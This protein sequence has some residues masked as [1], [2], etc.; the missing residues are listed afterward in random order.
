MQNKQFILTI[1]REFGSGG[2]EIAQSLSDRLGLKLYDRQILEEAGYTSQEAKKYD[3]KPVN[4]LLSRRI[5]AYSNSI[6]EMLALRTFDFLRKLADSGESFIVVGRCSE[7]VLREFPNKLSLF[8]LADAA[9]K[10]KKTM[11]IYG[12]SEKDALD[13]MRKQDKQRKSYHNYYCESKW[14]DSRGYDLCINTSRFGI[15]KTVDMIVDL[16]EHFV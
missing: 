2:H 10:T 3:E 7:Y 11:E 14:G 4:V 6:E 1:S 5:G 9:T 12:L 15:E 13:L 8:I 16:V